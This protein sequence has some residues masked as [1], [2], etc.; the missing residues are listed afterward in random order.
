MYQI[1]EYITEQGRSPFRRWFRK[2]TTQQ[3]DRVE[4]VLVRVS[5]GILGD[6][7]HVGEG[8]YELRLHTGPGYRIYF[9]REG[10]ELV[11]LLIGGDKSSQQRDIQRAQRFWRAHLAGEGDVADRK[12]GR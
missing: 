10:D 12:Q 7:K 9:G 8:V 11:I 5:D 2:L 3:A 4:D 1:R 6:T